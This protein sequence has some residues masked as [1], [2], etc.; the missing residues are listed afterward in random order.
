MRIDNPTADQIRK[1][2]I[3]HWKPFVVKRVGSSTHRVYADE[4]TERYGN[5][6]DIDYIT[7]EDTLEVGDEF[8]RADNYSRKV[9]AIV[10]GWAMYRV[11]NPHVS[12]SMHCMRV[13]ELMERGFKITKKGK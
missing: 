4:E 13:T 11:S 7:R 6:E 8:T 1:G 3:V 9:T 12:E 10:D 5:I 2:D